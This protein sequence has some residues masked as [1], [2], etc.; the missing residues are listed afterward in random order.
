MLYAQINAGRKLHLVYEPGEEDRQG[1]IVRIGFLSNPVC[2]IRPKKN[3]R[4]TINVPLRNACKLCISRLRGKGV[5]Q[6][7]E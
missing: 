1:N 3:Y 6:F 2:G 5:T 4:M 7:G